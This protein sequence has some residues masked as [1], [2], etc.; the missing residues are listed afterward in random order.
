MRGETSYPAFVTSAE[1]RALFDAARSA[2]WAQWIRTPADMHAVRAGCYFDRPAAKR[3]RTFFKQFL[4]H[5]TGDFVGQ[6]FILLPWQWRDVVAP[7]F[8]WKQ[9]DGRRRFDR[10]YLSCAKKNGKSGLSAGLALFLLIADGEAGAEVYSAAGDRDQAALIYREMVKMIAASPALSR[11]L[12]YTDSSKLIAGPDR[13]FYKAMSAEAGTKEGLN[14]SAIIFDELHAQPNRE[15]WDCLRY[16]GSARRQPLLLTITTAG[17]D[18]ET[19]CGEQYEY[20]KRVESGEVP[21]FKF[22][23]KIYEAAPED[24]WESEATWRQANPSLGVT[25]QMDQFRAAFLEAK[26]SPAKEGSFRRYR[27]NQ[28]V[29]T[30][31][32]WLSIEQW[33]ACG[34]DKLAA[35]DYDGL[36]CVG[37]LDLSATDDTT[38]LVLIFEGADG[39][40]DLLPFF[41]LPADNVLELEKRH[42]VP[43]RAWAKQGLIKLTPGN[44]VDYDTI[45]TDI[46]ALGKRFD[47]SQLAIDRKFQGQSVENDLIEDGFNVVAAGAGWVSQDLPAKELEKLLKAGL[48]RHGGHALLAWHASNVVVDIDKNN[49]YSINKRKSRSKID[50][51]AA[52]LMAMLLRM[53]GKSGGEPAGELIL[54]T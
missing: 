11:I 13:S 49:N 41:W 19:I 31:G 43:Y 4:R 42:R 25:V 24:D 53:G 27:L 20:A 34:A 7:L 51:I 23:A 21:D 5:A 35:Q 18:K 32:V 44:V 1:D 45:R 17:E 22:Y 37:G 48:I 29:K 36:P 15:L 2:R 12:H 6:A 28:W 33:K 14:A 39:T 30:E 9:A 52:L 10:G 47:I 40:I 8:G 26:S 46:N 38:A 50:G 16:A 3:V 54:L